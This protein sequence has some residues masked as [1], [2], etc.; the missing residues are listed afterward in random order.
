MTQQDKHSPIHSLADLFETRLQHFAGQT[1]L[2]DPVADE[3]LSYGEVAQ[4]V[5]MVGLAMRR[6]G[7]GKGDRVVVTRSWSLEAVCIAWST[8][9]LGAL[10]VPLDGDLGS[11]PLQTSLTDCAPVLVFAGTEHLDPVLAYC[12]TVSD[13]TCILLT[14]SA[15]VSSATFST[16]TF[17]DW[18]ERQASGEEP[19]QLDAPSPNDSAAILYT[20][21][22]TGRRKGVVLTHRGL[23]LS[24][25]TV[26]TEFAFSSRDLILST[27]DM[28]TIGSLRTNLAATVIAGSAFL[29]PGKS[30]GDPVVRH[31]ELATR[32]GAT[33][34]A[35]TPP[36]LRRMCA[37][38]E[39]LDRTAFTAMRWILSTSAPLPVALAERTKT[40]TKTPVAE[41]YG[42][43]ETTGG[44]IFSDPQAGGTILEGGGW[45]RCDGVRLVA[46]DGSEIGEADRIG[47]I[48]FRGERLMAGY[49]RDPELSAEVLRDGWLI[50]GD[51][52]RWKPD[53]RLEVIG[54]RKDMI[55]DADGEILYPAEVEAALGQLDAWLEKAVATGWRGR[56]GEEQLVLFVVPVESSPPID[57]LKEQ[58]RRHIVKKLGRR[59]LP[60]RIIAV[61]EMPYGANEK[62]IKH[63]LIE[64]HLA[65]AD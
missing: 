44:M 56:D 3:G 48:E 17:D 39:R 62:V 16:E 61:K 54:R 45:C 18:L 22:T 13:A 58:I 12:R 57:Q 35:S 10:L 27:G 46:D 20:S 59:A 31:L 8:F 51:L 43:T 7:V 23:Y 53:G 30:N 1:Y 47:G 4:M 50:T 41:F 36:F 24:G 65:G 29:L 64:Q 55:K 11:S 34:L 19:G 6:Q 63:L 2:V 21:G 25:L 40:L 52:G 32:Y 37:Y 28:H 38:G 26:A 42:L 14:E 33:I 60:K 9:R 5:R 49:W 15:S